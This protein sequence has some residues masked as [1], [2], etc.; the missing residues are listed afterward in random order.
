MYYSLMPPRHL[1]KWHLM[2]YSI[3]CV[4]VPCVLVLPSDYIIIMY[5]NQSCYVKWGNEHSDSF[6]LSNGVKQGGVVS[7]LLFS[8]YIDN[9]FHN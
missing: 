7:P 9:L 3:N 2:C 1:I 4:I 5:T 6:N 8:C